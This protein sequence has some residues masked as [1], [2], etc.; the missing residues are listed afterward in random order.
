MDSGVCTSCHV[1]TYQNTDSITGTACDPCPAGSSTQGI[2]GSTTIENYICNIGHYG[3]SGGPCTECGADMYSNSSGS[4]SCNTCP[5]KSGTGITGSTTIENRICNTR[6]YGPSGGPCTECGVDMYSDSPG[7][8][9]CSTCPCVN[10]GTDRNVPGYTNPIPAI[11]LDYPPYIVSNAEDRN[12]DTGS[13]DYIDNL[14]GSET[15]PGGQG[16]LAGGSLT[17]GEATGDGGV[18][19][20]YMEGTK[21]TKIQ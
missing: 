8:L 21:T 16:T 6:H 7:S 19:V 18:P 14:C 12:V 13:F 20:P 4:L 10:S 9:S 11:L 2:T 15:C 17:V 3:P 5:A 1:D